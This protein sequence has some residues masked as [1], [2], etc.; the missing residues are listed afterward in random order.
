[1]VDLA[2]QQLALGGERGIAVA[3]GM[4]LGLGVIA[5][6]SNLRLAQ[7]AVE[8]DVQQRDEIAERI[9]HQ[10]IGSAGLQGRDGNA[11]I[12]RGR[13]EHHRRCLRDRR[14]DLLEGFEAIEAVHVLIERDDVDAA[15]FQAI[16]PLGTAR[17]TND[18]EAEPGQAAVDQPGKRLVIVDIQ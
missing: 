4:D 13:D 17:C 5:G 18:V 11:R 9:F 7:C 1:M 8:R 2:Q 6:F 14:H 10:I 15:L 12:L 16:E 3:R